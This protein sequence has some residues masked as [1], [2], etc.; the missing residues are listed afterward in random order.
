MSKV[1]FTKIPVFEKLNI[2]YN[3]INLETSNNQV[4]IE[5]TEKTNQYIVTV[6]ST[7]EKHVG[8]ELWLDLEC[9]VILIKQKGRWKNIREL[10]PT[11]ENRILIDTIK[12]ELVK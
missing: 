8:F 7:D 11:K 9:N 3:D 10:F 1:L 6:N 2:R 4:K 12:L 5:E